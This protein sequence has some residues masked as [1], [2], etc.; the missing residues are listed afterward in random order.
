MSPAEFVYDTFFS[1]RFLTASSA[2]SG[3][4]M[5]GQRQASAELSMK[6]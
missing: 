3:D 5:S 1:F 6:Y 4:L 2:Q